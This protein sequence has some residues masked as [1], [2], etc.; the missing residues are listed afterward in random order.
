ML[1]DRNGIIQRLLLADER[2][3]VEVE[4]LKKAPTM[5]E[6]D[7]AHHIHRFVLAKMLLDD[8]GEIATHDLNE[9]AQMSV[10]KAGKLNKNEAE[11][12]DVSRHCGGTSSAMTK[13]VLLFMS[14][15]ESLSFKF[16]TVN[17]AE[18]QS[19]EEL[20]ATIQHLVTGKA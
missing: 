17:T 20:A 9:L 18:I 14:L 15:E 7:Y 1:L 4:A 11:L 5:P 19:T 16:G 6:T 2:A 10:I 13:K 3:S 8:E 12:L